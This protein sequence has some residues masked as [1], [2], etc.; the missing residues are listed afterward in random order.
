MKTKLKMVKFKK[1]QNFMYEAISLARKSGI[2]G[3]VPIGALIVDEKGHV[4]S[5]SENR[6]ERESS[7]LAHAELLCISEAIKIKG[8]SRL[9]NCDLWVTL[10]PCIMCSGAII[11]ARLRRVYFGAYDTKIGALE[12]NSYVLGLKNTNHK[13]E[14]YGGIESKLSEKLLNDFFTSKR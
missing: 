13:L 11:N 5:K 9:L 3:E 1:N 6:I 12:S 7:S 8:T 4:L 14:I 10:E 2:A